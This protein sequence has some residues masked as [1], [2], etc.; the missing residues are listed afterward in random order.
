MFSRELKEGH[1]VSNTGFLV[2]SM[3]Y[4]TALAKAD[5]TGH[6][7]YSERNIVG[8]L[9]QTYTMRI[10]RFHE[11]WN[12]GQ[13]TVERWLTAYTHYFNHLRGHQALDDRLPVEQLE[14]SI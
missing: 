3:G 11:T 7:N 2:D 9:F 5:P 8:K 6:L 13:L 12:G 10:G 1:R 4:L 14:E